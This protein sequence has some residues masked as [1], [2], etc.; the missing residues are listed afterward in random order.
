MALVKNRILYLFL[1]YF[2]D[3]TKNKK[4]SADSD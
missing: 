2:K 1:L 3:F 4:S